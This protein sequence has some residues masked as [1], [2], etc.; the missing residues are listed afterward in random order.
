MPHSP[1]PVPSPILYLQVRIGWLHM[2]ILSTSKVIS[3]LPQLIEL[4]LDVR[5]SEWIVW[6]GDNCSSRWKF[7][8][9]FQRIKEIS[10]LK[11]KG[12]GIYTS[13]T[14]NIVKTEALS[15]ATIFSSY[16]HSTTSV[17]YTEIISIQYHVDFIISCPG[18]MVTIHDINSRIRISYKYSNRLWQ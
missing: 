14:A 5:I 7:S 3:L 12:N 9:L 8:F 6:V 15:Q 2:K 1:L 17:L 11:Q 16:P 4:H 13:F 18:S 10:F